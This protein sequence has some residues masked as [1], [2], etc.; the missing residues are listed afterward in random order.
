MSTALGSFPLIESLGFLSD[1]EV[2]ALVAPDG[3]IEW[4]C[5]PRPDSPSVFGAI[6]DRGAG[7]WRIGPVGSGHA[8]TLGYEPGTL[9]VRS[10]WLT[11][12]GRLIVD[13]ALAVRPDGTAAH[14]L[15]RLIRC[16]EGEVALEA[17][18]EPA[19]DY[20]RAAGTWH[21][22]G[23]LNQQTSRAPDGSVEL[24][25]TT[26]LDASARPVAGQTRF[27]ALTGGAAR[28][29]T[30]SMRRNGCSRPRR[31]T[32][33]HGC[34]AARSRSIRGVRSSSDPHSPSRA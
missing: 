17:L 25:L 3:R 29:R 12:T 31:G 8:A 33:A 18:C 4:L 21:R 15:V 13:D 11:D 10:T 9:T 28:L 30:A 16:E 23:P 14:I 22:D 7:S 19:F 1:G 27:A 26:D 2:N 20:G 6:L 24:V 32:G 34:P 5:L